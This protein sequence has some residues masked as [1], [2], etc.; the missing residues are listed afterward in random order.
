MNPEL[1]RK[2]ALALNEKPLSLVK[3]LEVANAVSNAQTEEDLPAWIRT[4]IGFGATLKFVNGQFIVKEYNSDQPRDEAGRFSSDGSSAGPTPLNVTSDTAVSKQLNFQRA[5]GFTAENNP[6][7]WSNALEEYTNGSGTYYDINGMLRE[8]QSYV[9]DLRLSPNA[10]SVINGYIASLDALIDA[11]PPL[12]EPTL[13]Y[14]GIVSPAADQFLALRPGDSFTDA[15][16]VSTSWDRQVAEN[17]TI[18]KGA[19]LEVINPAGTKGVSTLGYE[20][21]VLNQYAPEKEWLLP[22]GTTFDVIGKQGNVVTVK[23]RNG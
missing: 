5:Q 3:H 1:S 22:R 14:R 10:V 18:D 11:A 2:A 8:G 19:I 6:T 4:Y 20:M 21:E 7:E 23:V 9:E 17:F 16:F 12:P 15:G 13:T